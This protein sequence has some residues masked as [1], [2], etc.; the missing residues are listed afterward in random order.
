MRLTYQQVIGEKMK[1]PEFNREWEALEPEFQLIRKI[2]E[3]D[4][5]DS[6]HNSNRKAVLDTEHTEQ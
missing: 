3:E 1:N 2:L 6:E 5:R 4:L